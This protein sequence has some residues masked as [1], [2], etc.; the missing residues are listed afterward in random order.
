MEYAYSRYGANGDYVSTLIRAPTRPRYVNVVEGGNVVHYPFIPLTPV[1]LTAAH[2]DML[3]AWRGPDPE[4]T[5]TSLSGDRSIVRWNPPRQRVTDVWDRYKAASLQEIPDDGTRRR[6]ARLYDQDL[7]LLEHVP[8]A[9]TLL[10][11]TEGNIWIERYRLPWV[12]DPVWDVIDA[13]GR[14][15]GTVNTPSRFSLF[16]IGAD[17][18]LGR[19]RDDLGV[20]RIQMYELHK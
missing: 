10:I 14:W 2:A 19:H 15:L 9:R 11:D 8:M 13:N 7:P 6:Y 4:I 1:P 5:S 3:Y 16:D 20:E 18:V 17:Y 12:G